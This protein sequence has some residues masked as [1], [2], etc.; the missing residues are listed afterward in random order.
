MIQEIGFIHILATIMGNGLIDEKIDQHRDYIEEK[1]RTLTL[2]SAR[3]DIEDIND[4]S[5]RLIAY[6]IKKE[7]QCWWS[8]SRYNL[9]VDAVRA[10][11]MNCLCAALLRFNAKILRV[12]SQNVYVEK[13]SEADYNAVYDNVMSKYPCVIMYCDPADS[14]NISSSKY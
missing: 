8:T 4:R 11:I 13:I 14:V 7:I 10:E 3:Y 9:Q 1:Y 6:M 12:N 2:L 5:R